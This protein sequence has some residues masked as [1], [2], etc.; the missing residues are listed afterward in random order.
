MKN[1][2]KFVFLFIVV[3]DYYF[4]NL[5]QPW[6]F[7]SVGAFGVGAVCRLDNDFNIR[8]HSLIAM[9]LAL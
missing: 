9:H 6:H 5:S 4:W 8:N 1:I 7:A 3:G 2:A